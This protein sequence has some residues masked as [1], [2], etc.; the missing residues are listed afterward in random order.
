MLRH[1]LPASPLNAPSA[2]L[3]LREQN[4]DHSEQ[5]TWRGGS[6]ATPS[7]GWKDEGMEV[8]RGDGHHPWKPAVHHG[9]GRGR[10]LTTWPFWGQMEGE[11]R[12]TSAWLMGSETD[13]SITGILCFTFTKGHSSPQKL[14]N[15]DLCY[16]LI[17]FFPWKNFKDI[18]HNHQTENKSFKKSFSISLCPSIANP[19]R[20]KIVNGCE[21]HVG[22]T[23]GFVQNE[24][25]PA[26]SRAVSYPAKTTDPASCLESFLNKRHGPSTSLLIAFHKKRAWIQE[27]W[28]SSP[29]FLFLNWNSYQLLFFFWEWTFINKSLLKHRFIFPTYSDTE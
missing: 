27:T 8:G 17:F 5:Q 7:V 13:Q 2:P 16:P 4:E 18:F 1:F 9:S 25:P 6:K 22:C 29:C 21:E 24:L 23:S 28:V 19:G 11:K 15:L 14:K 10:G 26:W 12:N 20:D 3:G